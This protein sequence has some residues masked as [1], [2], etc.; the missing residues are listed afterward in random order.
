M[1]HPFSLFLRFPD[2]Y[3]QRWQRREDLFH[4]AQ[5]TDAAQQRQHC[6]EPY[7][8]GFALLK[9]TYRENTHAGFL[10]HL[11]LREITEEAVVSE[12]AA[13]FRNQL[14]I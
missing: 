6:A 1:P 7:V 5:E 11:P 8:T 9:L 2:T 4:F 10:R 12:P 14:R 3:G 13:Q